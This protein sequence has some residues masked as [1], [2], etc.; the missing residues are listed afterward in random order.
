MTAY[1]LPAG[2]LIDRSHTLA[3]SFDGKN[4]AGHSG[5]TLASALLANDRL[6]VGRSFKYHRPRG[7]VT[8]GPSEPN[9]LVTIGSGVRRDPNTK[10]TVA[11]LYDG[12]VATSQNRWPSLAFDIGAVNGWMSRFLSAGFYYKTFMWPAAFWEK[13]YEPL[14]RRA[15][16]LG[17]TDL[18]PD[19]DS[20]E[21]SWAHC[22]LLVIGSGPAGLVAAL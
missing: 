21:R 3:F 6:L 15:A 14:I 1:R 4:L 20:Y 11:E 12:L 10:A 5:D 22:D 8:A 7:I 16:G 2:G 19:P 9:A 17:R 13:V 18:S